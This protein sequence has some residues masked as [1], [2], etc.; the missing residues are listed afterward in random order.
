MAVV[1]TA[2]AVAI[3]KATVAET[4]AAWIFFA[5]ES[6][7]YVVRRRVFPAVFYAW[8][9]PRFHDPS[10]SACPLDTR[11]LSVLRSVHDQG[12]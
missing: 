10:I 7:E 8:H 1:V 3:G 12:A 4:E 6:Q 2:N 5:H 9:P 11:L